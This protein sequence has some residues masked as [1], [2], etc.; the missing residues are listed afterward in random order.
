VKDRRK[1]I[2]MQRL[3][4][5]RCGFQSRYRHGAKKKKKERKNKVWT[6]IEHG[7]LTPQA[8]M[9]PPSTTEGMTYILVSK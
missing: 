5:I 6:R 8:S 3:E 1:K 4:N 7:S 9:L 2:K